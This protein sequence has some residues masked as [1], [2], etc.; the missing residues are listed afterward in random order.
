M[1]IQVL[2]FGQLA[3][4]TG[5]SRVEVEQVLDT[6]QLLVKLYARYPALQE[7]RFVVAVNNVV[8]REKTILDAHS[9]IALLPPFSGG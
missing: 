2:F 7:S 1:N 5:A 8:V 4:I 3:D 9:A 6:E